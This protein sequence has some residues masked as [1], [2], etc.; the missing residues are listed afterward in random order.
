MTGEFDPYNEWLGIPPK[1][2]P[3][4]Y[5]QLL[6]IKLFEDDLHLITRAANERMRL[7]ESFRS[8]DNSL[9][10]KIILKNI[11]AAKVCLLEPIGKTE[12]DKS[13]RLIIQSPPSSPPPPPPPPPVQL[14]SAPI[15]KDRR[16]PRINAVG[17]TKTTN[18]T[19]KISSKRHKNNWLFY[20][21]IG[22]TVILG[23]IFITIFLMRGNNP[24]SA[25]PISNKQLTQV[26]DIAPIKPANYPTQNDK[27]TISNDKAAPNIANESVADASKIG[28]HSTPYNNNDIIEDVHDSKSLPSI[29]P[30]KELDTAE[31]SKP[32]ETQRLPESSVT[33]NKSHQPSRNTSPGSLN[34]IPLPQNSTQKQL[35]KDRLSSRTATS[36]PVIGRPK[37]RYTSDNS[38]RTVDNKIILNLPSGKV[39]KS[40]LFDVEIRS[41]ENKL[42]DQAGGQLIDKHDIGK[43][44]LLRSP[45][46]KT[47]ALAEHDKGR[48]DGLYLAFYKFDIPMIYANYTDG[49]CNGIIK[50]WNENG[51]RV[52]WCQYI[53]GFRHGFCCYFKD[54]SLQ[55]LLEI[56][57]NNIDAIHLCSNGELE[58][59]FVSLQKAVAD[60][61]AKMLID[62][63]K[64]TESELKK[65]EITYKK[66]IRD[67]DSRLRQQRASK[68][69]PQ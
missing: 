69:T 38:S 8:D 37:S 4:N 25:I 22:T 11:V 48:L 64:E 5:Y 54:D 17:K 24:D 65:M 33:D 13:L 49:T 1:D 12:Y 61:D 30:N 2:Q 23:C 44:I 40:Q 47:Y 43:I 32:N 67:E 62:E 60:E 42:K 39:F 14:P 9:L 35:P 59:S 21:G 15:I 31:E 45:S 18:I 66:Q 29:K 34:V 27:E 58:K 52:Y 68:L 20:I 10:L 6:G 36:P 3:P 50:K 55:I 7:V 41:A 56:N 16:L 51:E 26:A 63:L 46:S 53:N 57:H 28:D 19:G